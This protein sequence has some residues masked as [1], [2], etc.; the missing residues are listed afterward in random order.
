MSKWTFTVVNLLP[1]MSCAQLGSVVE[2]CLGGGR[3]SQVENVG[4][5]PSEQYAGDGEHRQL[6]RRVPVAADAI[7]RPLVV[8]YNPRSVHD[9]AVDI[10]VPAGACITDEIS[11]HKLDLRVRCVEHVHASVSELTEALRSPRG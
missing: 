3:A 10:L 9:N 7:V 6:Q 8:G 11:D 5:C 1:G 4:G 2:V